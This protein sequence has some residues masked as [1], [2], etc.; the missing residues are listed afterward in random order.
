MASFLKKHRGQTDAPGHI[1]RQRPV[2]VIA[3]ILC[4]LLVIYT[5]L[6]LFGT[7]AIMVVPRLPLEGSPADAGLIYENIS[8]P[9]RVDSLLLKGWYI[10]GKG[11]KVIIV[12][13]G[14]YQNRV[15]EGVDT[16]NLARDLNREGFDLLLFDLRGRGESEGTGRSMMYFDRD[17]GGA[18]DY[19]KNRGFDSSDV[20]MLGFCSGAA[21]ACIFAGS[22]DVGALVLDGCFTSISGMIKQ[23][24]AQKNI[25]GALVDVFI[26]GLRLGSFLFFGYHEI[27]PLQVVGKIDSPVLFIHEEYDDVITLDEMRLLFAKAPNPSNELWEIPG[28]PHSEGYKT[29]PANYVQKVSEFFNDSLD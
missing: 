7:I 22:N 24:A 20:G 23:Q 6:S 21:S 25:P 13:H 27:A 4:V 18:L 17:L 29:S 14:G 26:P 1:S 8:F 2:K 3:V 15:D 5:G 12:I 9:S 19:V 10:P 28:A 11:E 16:L